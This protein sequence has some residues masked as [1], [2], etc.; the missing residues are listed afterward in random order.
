MS[1]P[2]HPVP[3][4]THVSDDTTYTFNGRSWDRTIIGS[5][6]DTRYS[7]AVLTTTLLTRITRLEALINNGILFLD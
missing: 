3:G 4:D 6:N 5:A 1:F 7:N 2:T